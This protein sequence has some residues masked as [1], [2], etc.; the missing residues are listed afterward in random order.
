MQGLA[1]FNTAN[2][3]AAAAA[4]ISLGL[5]L[6]IIKEGLQT[7][8]LGTRHNA[9]RCELYHLGG[10]RVLLDYAHNPVAIQNILQ[11]AKKLEPRRLLGVVG[12]PGDRR[13][14]DIME[15]GRIAGNYLDYCIFKEDQDLRGRKAGEAASLLWEGFKLGTNKNKTGEIILPELTAFLTALS[16]CKPG[17]LLVVLYEKLEPLQELLQK[18]EAG[19][20][21][22]GNSS[23]E[24]ILWG[25]LVAETDYRQKILNNL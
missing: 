3:L 21:R 12:V 4:C 8:N 15:A 20:M 9:G 2:A 6:S 11:Y 5:P 19:T 18:L 7:F 16:K 22:E 24:E 13:D 25:D 17:D 23:K 1:S 10:V 14:R